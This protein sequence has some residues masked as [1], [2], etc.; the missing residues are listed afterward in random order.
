MKS[1]GSGMAFTA[2]IGKSFSLYLN[3]N[4][5]RTNIFKAMIYNPYSSVKKGK[6]K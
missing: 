4:H 1:F 2:K 5:S 3:H 6:K